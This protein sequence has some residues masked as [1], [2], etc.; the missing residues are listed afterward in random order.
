MVIGKDCA[1]PKTKNWNRASVRLGTE[2]QNLDTRC[3]VYVDKW[4]KRMW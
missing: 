2:H 4:Q 3:A 1:I